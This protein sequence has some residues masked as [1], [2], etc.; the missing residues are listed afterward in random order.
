MHN[1][2]KITT[3]FGEKL[4]NLDMCESISISDKT[5]DFCY[6]IQTKFTREYFINEESYLKIKHKLGL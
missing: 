2:I 4:I 5:P 6:K 1:W 3:Q